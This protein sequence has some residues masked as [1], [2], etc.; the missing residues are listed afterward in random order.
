[1]LL[2]YP[3]STEQWQWQE[4]QG[5]PY[6][7]CT[8]LQDWCHGFF[9]QDFY[10]RTPESLIEVLQPQATVF[11]VKQVHGDRCLT[12]TEIHHVMQLGET[13]DILPP[14]DAVITESP[15]QAVWVASADCTPVLIGDRRTGRV[16]AIH[17]GWRGT[18]QRIVPKTLDRFLAL[19]S[20]LSD[21]SIALG[22]AIAG[23]VYPVSQEVA[24]QVG[25]SVLPNKAEA[26][27][28][29]QLS[30]Q[31]NPPFLAD[32]EPDKV[33][34]DVRRINV[35]QL[36]DL[37]VTS[38]QMAIAPCCTYQQPE[39]FFS[40]RRTQEKKVQWSGIVSHSGSNLVL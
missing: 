1:M 32:E 39:H 21:L 7:T 40:Y 29:D 4:G 20:Q 24:V 17:A 31:D 3:N 35:L 25:K 22:P 5:L 10:P 8:L 26:E 27:I 37:G 13:E 6:L 33:R 14:A 18:A 11:R 36:L 12:P 38:E 16:A 28:L 30:H 23:E 19:G 34:L 15:N 9:T 2:T